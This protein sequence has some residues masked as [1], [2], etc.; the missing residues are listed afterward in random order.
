MKRVCAIW[1][2]A[3]KNLLWKLLVVLALMAAA[4]LWM[5]RSTMPGGPITDGLPFGKW[6]A[7]SGAPLIF[8][9]AF[10][11]VTV[12]MSINGCDFSGGKLRYTLQRLPQS[13][14]AVTTIWAVFNLGVYVI[15]WAVELAVVL[16][17]WSWYLAAQAGHTAPQLELL[18]ACYSTDYFLHGLFPLANGFRWIKT[19]MGI[20]CLSVGAAH[21]GF[22]QRRGKIPYSLIP[23]AGLH[24]L[25]F[26]S[27]PRETGVDFAVAV[28]YLAILVY[29]LVQIWRW[30]DETD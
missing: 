21:F 9:I 16:V 10:V 24:W 6:L 2:A 3:A 4:E 17:C 23:M 11:L 18:V 5:F 29:D 20:L 28:V 8:G 25:A 1:M 30:E 19:I 26:R 7:D 27:S 13:E 14:A 12:L 15:L 22:R